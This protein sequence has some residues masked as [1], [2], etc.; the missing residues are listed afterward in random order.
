MTVIT[1]FSVVF[2]LMVV[3]FLPAFYIFLAENSR[4][5]PP[6]TASRRSTHTQCTKQRNTHIILFHLRLRTDQNT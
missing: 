3:E 2:V 1:T 6:K 4:Y 5:D